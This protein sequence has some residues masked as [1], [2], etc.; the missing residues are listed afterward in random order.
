MTGRFWIVE[1]S[2]GLRG[3]LRIYKQNIYSLE[4]VDSSLTWHSLPEQ[5]TGLPLKSQVLTDSCLEKIYDSTTELRDN[6]T[7]PRENLGCALL[8]STLS[9]SFWDGLPVD[10]EDRR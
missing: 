1:V 6:V 7:R 3:N 4:Q 8:C 2:L 9:D 10:L 5:V